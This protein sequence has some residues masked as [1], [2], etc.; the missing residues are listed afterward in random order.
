[1]RRPRVFAGNQPTLLRVA[2]CSLLCT[3]ASICA[4]TPTAFARTK[5][6]TVALTTTVREQA[7]GPERAMMANLLSLLEVSAIRQPGIDVVERM[8]LDTALHELVL[9]RAAGS[10]NGA[11][12][13][14]NLALAELILTTKLLEPADDGKRHVLVR[15][16]GSLTGRIRGA[17]VAPID[18]V[19]VEETAQEIISYL[20]AII[21]A[22]ETAGISIAVTPFESVGRFDRLRPLERGLRDMMVTRLLKYQR[23]HVLQ[24]SD[25][26]EL[27]DEIDLV[28]MGLTDVTRLPDTFPSRRAAYVIRGTIDE[29]NVDGGQRLIVAANVVNADTKKVVDSIEFQSMPSDVPRKLEVHIHRLTKSISANAGRHDGRLTPAPKFDEVEHLFQLAVGDL[30]RFWRCQPRDF[31]HRDFRLPGVAPPRSDSYSRIPLDSPL[32]KAMLRKATDRLESVLYLQPERREAAFAL[33]FCLIC[34]IE[35]LWQPDRAD[36]LLRNVFHHDPSDQMAAASLNWLAEMYYHHES[37]DLSPENEDAA[38]K[39]VQFAFENMPVTHRN[40]EWSRLVELLKRIHG[41]NSNY[42]ATAR[43]MKLAADFAVEVEPPA[44]RNLASNVANIAQSLCKGPGHPRLQAEARQLLDTW[45]TSEHKWQ[46]YSALQALA[47]VAQR[48]KDVAKAVELYR[49]AAEVMKGA[50]GAHDYHLNLMRA[51][52]TLRE[53]GDADDALALLQSFEPQDQ[54]PTSLLNGMYGIELGATLEALGRK[55]E[56]LETYVSYAEL[57]APLADNSDVEERINALGGVPLR[58]DRDID[59]RHING[60]N[61]TPFLCRSLATDGERLFAGGYYHAKQPVATYRIST[62]QWESIGGPDVGASCLACAGGYL[63]VGT[64]DEGLWRCH[65]ATKTWKNWKLED[66]LPDNKVVDIAAQQDSAFISVG[67]R[68]S[69]GVIRIDADNRVQIYEGKG[70]PSGTLYHLTLH[71]ARLY[72]INRRLFELE[73]STGAWHD[74]LPAEANR[75]FGLHGLFR[76]GSE[77]WGSSYR[78]EIFRINASS[79]DNTLYKRAWFPV[80][81]NSDKAGYGVDFALVRNGQLWFGGAPW[82]RFKS[83]GF[84]RLDLK[85]GDFVIYGPR[86]GFRLST[87]YE[88]YDGLEAAGRIWLATSCGLAEVAIRNINK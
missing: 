10:K 25:L 23:F 30:Y 36:R 56:A 4:L 2:V 59:V 21:S 54:R 61:E 9:N 7:T 16:T 44:Q 60:P 85:T 29:R 81:L 27:L 78:S 50:R 11:L 64:K 31:S 69:G 74:S 1:M 24:R 66:N 58:I 46:R 48:D 18:D 19:I 39:Q 55:E 26:R 86:D 40:F 15:I 45:S 65:L 28:R 47:Q 79:D 75:H 62:Q 13:L 37:G 35:D 32:G 33:A 80:E 83:C 43:L 20:S 51:A 73:P 5:S 12:Q 63:W 3:S 42:D 6:I 14:G 34:H 41:Q 53:S 72:G 87:T 84:Y 8:E 76:A 71:N 17:T 68:D 52:R 49:A 88:C 22:P 38:C 70:A 82:A 67:H 77:L 57:S